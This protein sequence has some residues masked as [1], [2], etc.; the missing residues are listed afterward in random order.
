MENLKKSMKYSI[1]FGL[2]GAV[3]IPVLYEIY[4]NISGT[5]SVVLMMLWV[6]FVGVK[7]SSFPFKEAFI[8]ITCDI[9]YSGVLGLICY[10][11][12][13]PL[14]QKLLS[15][16][17]VYF[18]LSLKEQAMFVVYTFITFLC[19]YVIWLIRLGLNAAFKQFRRNSEKAGEYIDNAFDE[20]KEDLK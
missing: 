17:S 19:M 3:L 2:T 10:L 16:G 4:A 15:G 18:Q 14:T 11:I 8:G 13:H 9:A 12:I 6:I 20:S 1:A 5:V 7:F